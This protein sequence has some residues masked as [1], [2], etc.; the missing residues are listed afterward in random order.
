DRVGHDGGMTV[1][2]IGVQLHQGR[3][4]PLALSSPQKPGLELSVFQ[5]PISHRPSEDT[6][7]GLRYA[8]EAEGCRSGHQVDLPG[9]AVERV[10]PPLGDD[11]AYV[12]RI[13]MA[14]RGRAERAQQLASSLD[15]LRRPEQVLH[16]EVRLD[17][18]EA[19][20]TVQDDALRHSVLTAERERGGRVRT[21]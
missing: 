1:P 9:V 5:I 12:A 13:D 18:R 4:L 6:R 8:I 11:R 17:E 2:G 3:G 16:E 14:P 10:R 19:E 20:P 15:R 7:E 21:D